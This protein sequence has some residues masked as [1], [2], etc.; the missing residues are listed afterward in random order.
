MTSKLVVLG[1]DP[2]YRTG[3]CIWTGDKILKITTTS[4]DNMF[5]VLSKIK[6]EGIVE[7]V[8]IEVSTSTH[9]YRRPDTSQRAMLRI[10]TNVGMNRAEALRLVGIAMGLG[11]EVVQVK[12]QNTKM[13]DMLFK[14]I[15]GYTK[16]TSSHS[17]D[18]Y[19]IANRVYA[20][21]FFKTKIQE[22]KDGKAKTTSS[23]QD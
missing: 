5:D 19:W 4:K 7:V 16:R 14:K 1:I 12:P 2:G 8:G 10:A 23:R 17:R 13:D 21:Q 3:Y 18:A 11:F 9:I 22:A 6:E 20:D 15:T